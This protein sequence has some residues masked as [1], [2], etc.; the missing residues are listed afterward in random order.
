MWQLEESC[1]VVAVSDLAACSC[2]FLDNQSSLNRMLA[3]NVV[4]DS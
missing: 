1:L 3:T 2:G 4:I